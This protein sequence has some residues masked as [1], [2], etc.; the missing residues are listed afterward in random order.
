MLSK[1]KGQVL[2]VAASLQVLFGLPS[3]NCGDQ[4][5]PD[6]SPEVTHIS[7]DSIIA[8]IN[9]IEV[10]CEQTAYIA[11]RSSIAEELEAYSWIAGMSSCSSVVGYKCK[12]V[13]FVQIATFNRKS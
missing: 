6:Q 10:C 3:D 8:A 13:M 12:L 11:G 4:T 1:S 9:F 5:P 7:E 2:R